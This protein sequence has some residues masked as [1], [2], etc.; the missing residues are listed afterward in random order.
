MFNELDVQERFIWL[1]GISN[2]NGIL[3]ILLIRKLKSMAPERVFGHL[4][5]KSRN[6]VVMF[7]R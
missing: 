5:K 2:I 4:E 7:V 1:G 6:T 3:Q